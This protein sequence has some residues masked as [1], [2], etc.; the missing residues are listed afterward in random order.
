MDSIWTYGNN[1]WN[2]EF[3]LTKLE[4]I[5]V[6]ASITLWKKFYPTSTTHLYCDE[7]VKQYLT[8][9][10]LIHFW[11]NVDTSFLQNQDVYQR[12]AFW[13]I[14]KIRLFQYI[15]TPFTFMDF[16]FYIK[17]KLPDYTDYDYVCCFTE[18]TKGY[19]PEYD[20]KEFETLKFPK[21]FT[22]KDTA[23]N[24]CFFYVNNSDVTKKYTDMCLSSMKQIND[25]DGVS[26]GHSVFL[27]QTILYELSLVNG[28]KTK[29]LM[30]TKFDDLEWE[31]G[32][33]KVDGFLTPIESDSYYRHLSTDKRTLKETDRGWLKIQSEIIELTKKYNPTLLQL[34]FKLIKDESYSRKLD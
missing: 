29:T 32:T 23:H 20:C 6:F 8:D 30:D 4:L 15:K 2:T 16:D 33:E 28:W 19:Y 21:E 34:L 5:T 9:V 25:I 3:K 24:T 18:N 12:S 7:S 11:D 17:Q 27:E 10:G 1:N 22:F 14:D 26:S 31:I 13:T